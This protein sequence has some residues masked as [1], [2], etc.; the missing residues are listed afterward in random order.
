ME[1]TRN[2]GT[3]EIEGFMHHELQTNTRSISIQ[4]PRGHKE[5]RASFPTKIQ[6]KVFTNPW[7]KSYLEERKEEEH[8]GRREGRLALFCFFFVQRT[9]RER[10]GAPLLPTDRHPLPAASFPCLP[11]LLLK[12]YNTPKCWNKTR[13]PLGAKPEKIHWRPSDGCDDL[14]KFASTWRNRPDVATH[15]SGIL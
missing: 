1:E 6:Y 10:G 3:Q 8:T 13:R 12:D 15:P 14:E 5:G 7:L 11:S 4:K 9:A 2:Q